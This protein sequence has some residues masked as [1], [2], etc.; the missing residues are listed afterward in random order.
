MAEGKRAAKGRFGRAQPVTFAWAP[1]IWGQ[2]ALLPREPCTSRLGTDHWIR[3]R[4]WVPMGRP[5]QSTLGFWGMGKDCQNERDW[6]LIRSRVAHDWM[7]RAV[8]LWYGSRR[9]GRKPARND[10]CGVTRKYPGEGLIPSLASMF[11]QESSGCSLV[12]GECRQGSRRPS[13]IAWAPM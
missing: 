2:R 13:R 1:G 11:L 9:R 6:E 3:W 7:F 4:S 8:V 12:H 10:F 5:R